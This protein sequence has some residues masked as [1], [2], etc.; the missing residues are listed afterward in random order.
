M[1]RLLGLAYVLLASLPSS[2]IINGQR[3]HVLSCKSSLE[4]PVVIVPGFAQS[5]D[6]YLA[7]AQA[8]SKQRDVMIYECKG[9]GPLYAPAIDGN[10]KGTDSNIADDLGLLPQARLLQSC[11]AS[12]FPQATEV[13]LVGFSLGGR[14]A[15]ALS[16]LYSSRFDDSADTDLSDKTGIRKE[17]TARSDPG[18]VVDSAYPRIRKLHLTGIGAFRD[19]EGIEAFQTWKDLLKPA[20]DKDSCPSSN[21]AEDETRRFQAFSQSALS[22]SYSQD[23]V[24]RNQ[25]KIPAWIDYLTN[26]HTRTGLCEFQMWSL[27]RWR[28]RHNGHRAGCASSCPSHRLGSYSHTWCRTR[29]SD[30]ATKRVATGCNAVPKY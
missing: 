11:I 9:M 30:R 28:R 13:D 5:I 21:I 17:D 7:H 15:L 22:M 27:V 19:K 6:A 29:C 18:S 2:T 1:H 16:T 12:A 23:F 24:Q 10:G 20:K 8:M 14:I 26:Q 4:S 3:C 25:V